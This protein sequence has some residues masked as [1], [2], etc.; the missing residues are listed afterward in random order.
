MPKHNEEAAKEC[1]Q[2]IVCTTCKKLW[3]PQRGLNNLTCPY[4][5]KIRSFG[6]KC[7]K[8]GHVVATYYGSMI[9]PK[10]HPELFTEEELSWSNPNDIASKPRVPLS[11]KIHNSTVTYLS[12]EP[13]GADY[14]QALW[15][16]WYNKLDE[17][18][19]EELR[20]RGEDPFD[21]WR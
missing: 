13:K 11:Q 14:T 20:N 15:M 4:C 6:F 12:D 3:V 10:C 16:E 1:E 8:C 17:R 18:D 5:K 7:T 9:C 19:H 21:P 2:K